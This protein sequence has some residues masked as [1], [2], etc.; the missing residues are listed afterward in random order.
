MPKPPPP[1]PAQIEKAFE[2]Y[3]MRL[4]I[5]HELAGKRDHLMKNRMSPSAIMAAND[6]I[7]QHRTTVIAAR[8]ALRELLEKKH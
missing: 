4:A 1:T 8:E 2:V 6:S 7:A 5:L 3:R